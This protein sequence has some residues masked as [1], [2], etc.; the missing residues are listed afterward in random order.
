ME[1]SRSKSP[2]MQ[3]ESATG[4]GSVQRRSQNQN[5]N[6]KSAH[7]LKQCSC[8][9][10]TNRPGIQAIATTLPWQVM[11]GREENTH[12][13]SYLDRDEEDRTK[14]LRKKKNQKQQ[15]MH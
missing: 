13:N 2:K 5:A 7:R 1:K 12:P 4:N 15:H 8:T 6:I 10:E 3:A 11:R 9:D 14:Y